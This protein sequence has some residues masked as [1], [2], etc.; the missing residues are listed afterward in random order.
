MEEKGLHSAKLGSAR[1][2]G[3]KFPSEATGLDI[4]K[5]FLLLMVL[6]KKLWHSAV[7]AH[8]YLNKV[9]TARLK[10]EQPSETDGL[11]PAFNTD[12]AVGNLQ[13]LRFQYIFTKAVARFNLPGG[14]IL[15]VILRLLL[16]KFIA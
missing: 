1:R 9:Y 16:N 4:K 2:Q 14:H 7:S 12:F 11:L 5:M 3:D 8:H 15:I 6:I 10:A 13:I